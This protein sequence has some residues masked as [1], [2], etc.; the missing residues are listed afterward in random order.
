MIMVWTGTIFVNPQ[1]MSLPVDNMLIVHRMTRAP[2]R[3]RSFSATVS[4]KFPDS[5]T[6]SRMASYKCSC[7]GYC[8]VQVNEWEICTRKSSPVV[9][10]ILRDEELKTQESGIDQFL[11]N[12]L[13]RDVRVG[14][15]PNCIC[16]VFCDLAVNSRGDHSG[17][18]S[19]WRSLI[20]IIRQVVKMEG[21]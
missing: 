16:T 5:I 18:S 15:N 4:L 12:V 14:D 17:L 21:D 9:M 6:L 11:C 3:R 19:P 13:D 20:R 7:L 2:N 1:P 10:E 8:P